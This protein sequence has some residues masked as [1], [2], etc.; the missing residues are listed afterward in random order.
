MRKIRAKRL[1]TTELKTKDPENLA[2]MVPKLWNNG[3]GSKA[4]SFSHRNDLAFGYCRNNLK[5]V[6]AIF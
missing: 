1:T 3:K 4:F 2:V 6:S 5:L